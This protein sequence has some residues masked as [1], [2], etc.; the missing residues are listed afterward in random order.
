[1]PSQATLLV[2]LLPAIIM[3]QTYTAGEVIPITV[4]GYI[5]SVTLP[6]WIGQSTT[7]TAPLTVTPTSEIISEAL[8]SAASQISEIQSSANSALDSTPSSM[9]DTS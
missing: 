3:A 5:T 6:Y 2:S 1:M 9:S 8:S 4:N 7:A